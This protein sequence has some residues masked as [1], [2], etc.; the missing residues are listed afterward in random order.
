MAMTF[1]LDIVSAE[2]KIFSGLT[3]K[4]IASGQLGE[5]GIFPG[6]TPL[7]TS[8]R[9]GLV[10]ITKQSGGEDIIYISGGILEVQPTVVTILADTAVRADDLDE[11]AALQAKEHAQ[12]IL[13]DKTATFEY[14]QALGEL[15]QATAQLKAIQQLRKKIRKA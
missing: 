4:V 11:A 12:R 6:H 7:L 5:L 9:P 15:A 1:H 3:E 8:L 13:A 2:A 10:K 14:A